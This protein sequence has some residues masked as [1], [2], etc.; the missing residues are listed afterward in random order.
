MTR[1]S[2]SVRQL[3]CVALVLVSACAPA[4]FE[5]RRTPG[6]EEVYREI[7][8]GGETRSYLVHRPASLTPAQR[9]PLFI[10]LHGT[11]GN[12]AGIAGTTGFNHAADLRR[13]VVAYPNGTGFLRYLTWNTGRCC[14]SAMEAKA[15]DVG[16]IHSMIQELVRTANID[17]RRV[18][19]VGFSDGGMMAFRAGCDL[20]TEIAGLAIV[21]GR[22][23]DT[24]CTARRALPIIAF[25]GTADDELATD[26]D[27]YTTPSSFRYAFSLD[28][29][30]AFWARRSHCVA[31]PRIEQRGILHVVSYTACAPRAPI[32]YYQVQ[33]AGHEWPGGATA[34]MQSSDSVTVPATRL[35]VEFLLRQRVRRRLLPGML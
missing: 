7:A 20:S 10:V 5:G 28:S 21:A 3:A 35:I 22:M 12:A 33:D 1:F 23:P 25:G 32:Q 34:I 17:P 4:M 30:L 11:H 18:F 16:F 14:G 29:S 27:R 9:P 24:V 26:H 8:V 15:N 2:C 31:T 13:F 6:D 19:V